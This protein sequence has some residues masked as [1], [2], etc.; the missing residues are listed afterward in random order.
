MHETSGKLEYLNLLSLDIVIEQFKMASFERRDVRIHMSQRQAQMFLVT[1]RDTSTSRS[2][3]RKR[4][5]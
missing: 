5:F 4:C 2:V 1:L 3:I